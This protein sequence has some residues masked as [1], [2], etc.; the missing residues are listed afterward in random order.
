MLRLGGPGHEAD[1]RL[2]EMW[3]SRQL[4][5]EIPKARWAAARS[6]GRPRR[7]HF[8]SRL[9]TACLRRELILDDVVSAIQTRSRPTLVTSKTTRFDPARYCKEFLDRCTN[10]GFEATE[11]RNRPHFSGVCCDRPRLK[12]AYEP[13]GRRFESCRARQLL[14]GGGPHTPPSSVARGAPTPR[15]APSPHTSASEL[16]RFE[17]LLR[18]VAHPVRAP[19]LPVS[20]RLVVTSV[21]AIG[22]RQPRP[23]VSADWHRRP[24]PVKTRVNL[25]KVSATPVSAT[26][27]VVDR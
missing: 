4:A 15:A 10:G 16:R 9:L 26:P 1:D 13:G 23:R 20:S 6:H 18:R 2:A 14:L 7:R 21:S 22:S 24:S 8:R 17:R 5:I 11:D 12:V 19:V 3:E 25:P 27:S